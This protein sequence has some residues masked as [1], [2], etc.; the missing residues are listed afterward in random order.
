MDSIAHVVARCVSSLLLER[1]LWSLQTWESAQLTQ[2]PVW[3]V[4]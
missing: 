4:A 2:V 3:A 1:W